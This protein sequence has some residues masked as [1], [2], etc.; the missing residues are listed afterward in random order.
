MIARIGGSKIL[1]QKEAPYKGI[2][3]KQLEEVL[4][5]LMDG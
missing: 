1:W 3:K 2:V 5:A 4:V